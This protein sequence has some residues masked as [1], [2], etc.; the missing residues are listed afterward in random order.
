MLPTVLLQF[1]AVISLV[2]LQLAVAAPIADASEPTLAAQLHSPLPM[3]L[4]P[5]GEM[6]AENETCSL[7][8]CSD[9]TSFASTQAIA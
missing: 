8:G 3:L 7:A 9:V 2:I 1:V 4:V 5:R 6:E